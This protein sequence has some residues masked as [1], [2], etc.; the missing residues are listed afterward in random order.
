[1]KWL[2]NQAAF[3]KQ[4]HII[5]STHEINSG[6]EYFAPKLNEFILYVDYIQLHSKWC[7]FMTKTALL[8]STSFISR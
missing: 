1:M 6:D 5:D 7:R 4:V 3:N 8:K 2:S